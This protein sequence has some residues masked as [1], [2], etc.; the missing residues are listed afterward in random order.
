[1]RI[2]D[3]FRQFT[4]KTC[5]AFDTKELDREFG[6]RMR[7]QEK[8]A[9]GRPTAQKSAANGSRRKKFNLLRYK[10]HSLGDYAKMIRHFGTTDSYSTE[11]VSAYVHPPRFS[12]L[13]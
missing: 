4:A 6:A 11:I 9:Q 2:G 3:K 10:Y 1:M 8:E 5:S 7:R 13:T 12:A